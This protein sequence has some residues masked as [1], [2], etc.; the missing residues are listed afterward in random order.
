MEGENLQ[1]L[2]SVV[3][4]LLPAFEILLSVSIP[5][6]MVLNSAVE[7][8]QVAQIEASLRGELSAASIRVLVVTKGSWVIV[9]YVDYL[10][11]AL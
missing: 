3:T 5:F 10:A 1:R 2:T 9:G 7:P 11:Y 6:R 8:P 4:K